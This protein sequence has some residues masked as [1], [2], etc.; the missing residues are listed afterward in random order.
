MSEKVLLCV[1]FFFKE[2]L[3]LYQY[4]MGVINGANCTENREL[5]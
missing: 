4:G 2:I 1:C 3:K 5:F